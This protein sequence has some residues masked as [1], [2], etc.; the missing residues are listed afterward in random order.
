MR[1]SAAC[2]REFFAKSEPFASGV[3]INLLTD[4]R[5]PHRCRWCE[6]IRLVSPAIAQTVNY[7]RMNQNITPV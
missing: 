2:L 6:Y 1:T 7:F 5:R 3:A 4:E